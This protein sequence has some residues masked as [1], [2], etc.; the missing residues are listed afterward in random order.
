MEG[1]T[2]VAALEGYSGG[3]CADTGALAR[4]NAVTPFTT[5][6]LVQ[7]SRLH[8]FLALYRSD[9]SKRVQT[10]LIHS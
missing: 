6:L 8:E 5:L 10:S 9:I 2:G 3:V 1:T 7:K 4:S